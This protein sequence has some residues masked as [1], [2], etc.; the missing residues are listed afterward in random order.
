[1]P[2]SQ[3]IA[4]ADALIARTIKQAGKIISLRSPEGRRV[5]EAL[6]MMLEEA[7]R[8]LARRLWRI[9]QRN[10]G[11]KATFS[12][13]S[14]M[15]YRSQIQLVTQYVQKRLLG[16][17]EKQAA[18]AVRSSYKETT[19]LIA[20]LE[21]RFSGMTV[22][23]RLRE[24]AVMDPIISGSK[25]SL[26]AQHA[27]SVDRYGRGMI[28]EFE[29]RMRVG[30]IEGK[31]H[32]EMTRDLVGHGGPRG[33]VSM[34]AKEIAPGVVERV[35][36]ESISEGLFVRYKYWAHRIVRTETA[37]AYQQTK[38]DTYQE[39]AATHMPDMQKKILAVLDNRTAPDSIAVHGQI[40]P[41]DG[42]FIDG[43]GRQYQRP[44][45]RPNDRETIIPWR[46]HWPETPR[47]RELSAA[48]RQK[49]I[50]ESIP[51][52][53]SNRKKTAEQKAAE[54][55]QLVAQAIEQQ[56]AALAARRQ[57]ALDRWE[58]EQERLIERRAQTGSGGK[59]PQK[60]ID[61]LKDIN[62]EQKKIDRAHRQLVGAPK[63]TKPSG[64]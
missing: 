43:A 3:Q 16:M 52:K 20:D 59:V 28:G 10:G 36:E 49:A 45:A 22:P 63:K 25:S 46:P 33:T 54:R 38:L 55:K 1:M 18:W 61:E 32:Y 53:A 19:Q 47:S 42:Y 57:Q 4:R 34:A 15:A 27:T 12:A 31:S 23:L 60:V 24:A 58:R 39:V 26:L 2:S 51:G 37:H 21:S 48:E 62:R 64:K 30:L 5:A 44:P 40:R 6:V 17:T 56:R 11:P 13:A 29:K 7:D 14:A 35:R 8:N 9:A 50:Q 41:I